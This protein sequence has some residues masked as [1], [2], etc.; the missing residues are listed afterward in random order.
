MAQPWG[1]LYGFKLYPDSLTHSVTYSLAAML[2][3]AVH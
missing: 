3:I 2:I 1:Q